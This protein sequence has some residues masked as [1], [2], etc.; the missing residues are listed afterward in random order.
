VT[1]LIEKPSDLTNNL[2]LVGFY[3]F[4]EG[5]ALTQA[6]E[7][8]IK[9]KINLKG[10]FFLADAI[11]LLL[12]GGAKLK[13]HRTAVW[14]DAGIPESLLETNRY[15]LDHG[16]G[17]CDVAGNLPAGT[18]IESSVIGPHVTLGEG[19][20]LKNVI[21]RNSIIEAGTQVTDM[22]IE[23]SLIGRN[24]VLEGKPDKLSIGDNSWLT[25]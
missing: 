11:N 17:N 22:V 9:R 6:I 13:S 12:E 15:L 5:G 2:V 7:E 23:G 24:V 21:V 16:R 10:E 3:Y 25:K 8:Q 1:R 4:R 20:K 19:T 14:L 18:V